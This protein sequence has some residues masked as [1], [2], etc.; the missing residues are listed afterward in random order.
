MRY[1]PVLFLMTTPFYAFGD[2]LS[3]FENK[4]VSCDYYDSNIQEMVH[5]NCEGSKIQIADCSDDSCFFQANFNHGNPWHSECIMW[6]KLKLNSADKAQGTAIAEYRSRGMDNRKYEDCEI[7]FSI[8]NGTLKISILSGCDKYCTPQE[9]EFYN[10]YHIDN[11]G[12][13]VT[14]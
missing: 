13:A 12:G 8:D 6:G 1:F 9:F 5:K 2:N 4:W 11:T 10:N 7:A 3:L 14:M